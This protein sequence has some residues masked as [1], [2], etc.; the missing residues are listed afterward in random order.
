MRLV[1]I[2]KERFG[3]TCRYISAF[4]LKIAYLEHSYTNFKNSW[5]TYIN[6]THYR[7]GAEEFIRYYWPKPAEIYFENSL[8]YFDKSESDFPFFKA[9]NGQVQWWSNM[10]A[11]FIFR[12]QAYKNFKRAD[13]KIPSENARM[14]WVMIGGGGICDKHVSQY[15]CVNLPIVHIHSNCMKNDA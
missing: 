7:V 14:V 15:H 11:S 2:A 8:A 5:N 1:A 10:I 12:G 6:F 4:S 3:P 9:T 13:Y